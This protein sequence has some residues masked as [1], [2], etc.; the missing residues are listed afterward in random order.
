VAL[1][2]ELYG[3][4][5]AS[6]LTM[7]FQR[8]NKQRRIYLIDSWTWRLV[9]VCCHVEWH[10]VLLPTALYNDWH[11][12][13]SVDFCYAFIV[14]KAIYSAG[15]ERVFSLMKPISMFIYFSLF[16]GAVFLQMF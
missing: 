3:R 4:Q 16:C 14:N 7:L 6:R 12:R 15:L 9:S 8:A 11:W 5:Q 2:F 10:V 13:A 1:A